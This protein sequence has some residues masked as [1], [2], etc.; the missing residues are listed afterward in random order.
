MFGEC[1]LEQ[2]AVLADDPFRISIAGQQAAQLLTYRAELLQV[3]L[4]DRIAR[5]LGRQRIA[6]GGDLV[7]QNPLDLIQ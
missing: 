3:N 6:D 4:L 7:G 2:F 1:R 5:G